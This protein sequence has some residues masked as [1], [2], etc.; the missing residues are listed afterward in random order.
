[1]PAAD[2]QA[3]RDA[4]F[5]AQMALGWCFPNAVMQYAVP[6]PR[7]AVDRRSGARAPARRA[8]RGADEVGLRRAAAGGDVLP[9]G[10]MAER[11][12]G[13]ALERARR[14]RRLRH[15]G[16]HHER[17]EYFRISLTA[18]DEMVERAL[19][20]FARGREDARR[21]RAAYASSFSSKS[22]AIRPSCN[23][24]LI[25]P[26]PRVTGARVSTRTRCWG[27]V[28]NAL[29]CPKPAGSCYHCPPRRGR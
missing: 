1:M 20:V 4:M 15:A 24:W 29:P 27:R 3:L 26:P 25:V 17:R 16:Q 18:S 14:P 13:A 2:R 21:L 10:Q 12:P 19:P 7:P 11:R 8:E 23:A 6:R 22:R 5:A 28:C 9:V